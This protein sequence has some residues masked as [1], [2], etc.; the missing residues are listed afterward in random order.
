[1]TTT[2]RPGEKIQRWYCSDCDCEHEASVI[3]GVVPPPPLE[4]QPLI[5]LT[6]VESER[7]ER[8]DYERS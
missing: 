6:E 5:T 8:E 3:G 1:M 7:E 2:T 4:Q